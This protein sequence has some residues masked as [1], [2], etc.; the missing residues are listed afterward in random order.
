[1]STQENAGDITLAPIELLLTRAGCHGLALN[2]KELG[3]S[4]QK[5]TDWLNDQLIKVQD[6]KVFM[7]DGTRFAVY[8]DIIDEAYNDSLDFRW[9]TDI[10]TF[11]VKMPKRAPNK[12]LELRYLIWDLAFKAND[13]PIKIKL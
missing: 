2:I 5:T 12:S 8:A 7:A 9:N 1:V 11:A 10:K 13:N 3:K 6:R 4:R